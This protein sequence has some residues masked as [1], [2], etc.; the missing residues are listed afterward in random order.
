MNISNPALLWSEAVFQSHVVNLARQLGYSQIYHTHDSRRSAP[1]F[2]DLVM[3]NS[4][5]GRVLFVELKTQSGKV[6]PEQE[7]W[8][9]A[10]RAAGQFAEVWRP[11]DWVAGRVLNA[12]SGKAVQRARA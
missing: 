8:I 3:V 9:N 2:P 7:L 4:K 12:L 1:G 11:G 6:R 10:L 5:A